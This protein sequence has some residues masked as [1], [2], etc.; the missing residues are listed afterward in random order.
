MHEAR[1]YKVCEKYGLVTEIEEGAFQEKKVKRAEFTC[2][3]RPILL[4]QGSDQLLGGLIRSEVD[5]L[6]LWSPTRSRRC[7]KIH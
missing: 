3:K 1:R 5:H 2:W 6:V 7:L 4:R